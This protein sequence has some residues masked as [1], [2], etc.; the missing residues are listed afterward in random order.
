MGTALSF[1]TVFASLSF[2]SCQDEDYGFT[3]NEIRDAVYDRNFI[4]K[5]G[6]IDP[7]QNW[8]L[9]RYAVNIDKSANT[10][11]L[12]DNSCAFDYD[13][14]FWLNNHI[15]IVEDWYYTEPQLISEFNTK[16][17]EGIDNTSQGGPFS[18]SSNGTPFYIIPVFQGVSGI[19]ADLHMVVTYNGVTYDKQI[20]NKSQNLEKQVAGSLTWEPLTEKYDPWSQ[21]GGK[22]E[23]EAKYVGSTYGAVATRT[24]P[25]KCMIPAGAS[26]KF[27]LHVTKGHLRTATTSGAELTDNDLAFTNTKQWSDKG[28]MIALNANFTVNQSTKDRFGKETYIIGCEDASYGTESVDIYYADGRT[29]KKEY[30]MGDTYEGSTVTKWSGDNDM[31]DLVFMFIADELPE[32]V[33]EGVIQKR[34]LIEDLGS[35]AD[36]DFND[37]VVDLYQKSVDGVVVDQKAMLRHKC[38]TTDFKVFVGGKDIFGTQ[39]GEVQNTKQNMAEVVDKTLTILQPTNGVWPWDPDQN[40]IVVEVFPETNNLNEGLEGWSSELGWTGNT[41]SGVHDNNGGPDNNNNAATSARGILVS[42]PAYGKV[43]RIIAVDTDFPWTD[44]NQDIDPS[45][46]TYYVIGTQVGM[47]SGT[48]E[49]GV[50]SGAGRYRASSKVT[51]K[52]IA[53]PGYEFLYWDDNHSLTNPIRDIAVSS[54]ANYK[55]IFKTS[56][57]PNQS[58]YTIKVRLENGGTLTDHGVNWQS[59]TGSIN[60]PYIFKIPTIFEGKPNDRGLWLAVTPADG[61]VFSHWSDENGNIHKDAGFTVKSDADLTA[62]FVQ[63][64]TLTIRVA[65]EDWKAMNSSYP[66]E[67]YVNDNGVVS[68]LTIDSN[69]MATKKVYS[70]KVTVVARVAKENQWDAKFQWSEGNPYTTENVN[71]SYSDVVN[72]FNS[73]NASSKKEI[74]VPN[75]GKVVTV[76]V[77]YQVNALLTLRSSSYIEGS[78][79]V[80]DYYYLRKDGSGDAD[81]GTA[82]IDGGSRQQYL[83]RNS[84]FNFEASAKPGYHFV[85]WNTDYKDYLSSDRVVRGLINNL[86]NGMYFADAIFEENTL[87][88]L[89]LQLKNTND[90]DE[91][92]SIVVSGRT[93]TNNGNGK[94]IVQIPEGTQLEI[95][96]THKSYTS[97]SNKNKVQ[98][99]LSSGDILENDVAKT[100]NNYMP[101]YDLTID[102]NNILYLVNVVLKNQA[103]AESSG[104]GKIKINDVERTSIYVPEGK[105]NSYSVKFEATANYGFTFSKWNKVNGYEMTDNPNY[106]GHVHDCT[107]EAIFSENQST[108]AID[109]RNTPFAVVNNPQTTFDIKTNGSSTNNQL[110][111]VNLLSDTRSTITFEFQ[112]I[113]SSGRVNIFF[114]DWDH[115]IGY[116]DVTNGWDGKISVKLTSEQVQAFKNDPSKPIFIQYYHNGNAN[117]SVQLKLVTI[118]R[119]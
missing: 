70:D 115:N 60:D 109:L 108:W 47:D 81:Y 43:P 36:W 90:Y 95:K 17:G 2:V 92:L 94:Y 53:N 72:N 96:A 34:Y 64:K 45:I 106:F 103:G 118:D 52:A 15:S 33:E 23:Y 6:P 41:S 26:I 10:R 59:G 61:Y 31:N 5:Y 78:T 24:K 116:K 57:T 51:L 110:H 87:R 35:V 30:H 62:H 20:W 101:G 3:K 105:D 32:I 9:S 16:L 84:S 19:V 67:L 80:G 100:L 27:Y 79:Q 22:Q 77:T 49:P 56:A 21:Y 112:N 1:L 85:Q 11:A 13:P 28:K 88:T 55:A 39:K 83:H 46:W 14:D 91:N 68:K 66:I 113:P 38:G 29:V 42:F 63:P 119:N 99:E 74:S 97:N 18:L 111:F 104:A 4:A 98:F 93:A 65:Q 58:D 54:A 71:S 75:E 102:V 40:N 117:Q 44:E 76:G 69:G 48:G 8:D 89:T 50:V 82:T 7:V 73:V 86:D 25:I 114:Q 107:I 12:P 37:I